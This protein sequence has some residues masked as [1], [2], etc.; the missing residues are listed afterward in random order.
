MAV[1]A[2]LAGEAAASNTA[3]SFSASA[4]AFFWSGDTVT[5]LA[6][7]PGLVSVC[8]TVTALVTV[9]QHTVNLVELGTQWSA[10][11]VVTYKW[12]G[13]VVVVS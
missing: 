1:E 11:C 13:V 9:T 6:T 12:L 3:A 7:V 8:E 10:E 4:W 2:L 5:G